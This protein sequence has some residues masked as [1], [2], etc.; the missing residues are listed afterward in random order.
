[1]YFFQ[2]TMICHTLT[3]PCIFLLSLQQCLYIS[4]ENTAAKTFKVPHLCTTQSPVSALASWPYLL[5]VVILY[6]K[7]QFTFRGFVGQHRVVHSITTCAVGYRF[8]YREA[9]RTV[10]RT[11]RTMTKR[12]NTKRRK[13]GLPLTS[14]AVILN[15]CQMQ[16]GIDVF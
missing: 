14:H 8:G 12:Q 7:H 5:L 10:Q 13:R 6:C 2:I 16:T 11:P 4:C 9:A 15:G 1:M 3:K